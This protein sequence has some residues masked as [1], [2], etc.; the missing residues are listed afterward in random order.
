NQKPMQRYFPEL[1]D[2]LRDQLPER[3]I[4]DGELVI[5]RDGGLDFDGLQQRIHPAESRIDKLATET[6]ASFVAFDILWL[7]DRDLRGDPF[8]ERRG[9]L[10]QVL[11]S[12]KPPLHLTP[13]TSDVDEAADWFVRFEGAGLD[14]VMAKPTGRPYEE[15]KRTQFKVKHRR[16]AD[17]VVA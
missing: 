10:E 16:T 13:T 9:L 14:G 7:D 12:A 3:C 17:C 2:P 1:L 6:P 8:A 4:V 11:G 5:A 15:D